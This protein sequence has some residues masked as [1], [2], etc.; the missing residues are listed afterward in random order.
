MLHSKWGLSSRDSEHVQ[1]FQA[2][3]GW[4]VGT[5]ALERKGIYVCIW[6][7]HFVVIRN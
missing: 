4:A 5:V 3:L 2:L 1:R 6:M 7:I